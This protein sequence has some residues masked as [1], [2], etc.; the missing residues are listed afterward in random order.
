M[1]DTEHA[2]AVL[3][4]GDEHT[5]GGEVIDL[6]DAF[7]V[8]LHLA[9]DAVKMLRTSLDVRRNTGSFKLLM[10]LCYGIDNELLPF[11][12]LVF[13]LLHEGIVRLGFEITQA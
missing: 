10:N 5:H 12:P 6:V 8:A 7:V 2:V 1:N 4:G 9:V 3:D 13:D 11:L